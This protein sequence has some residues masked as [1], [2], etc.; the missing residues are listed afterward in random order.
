[1]KRLIAIAAALALLAMAAALLTGCAATDRAA[2]ARAE[3]EAEAEW[4][5]QERVQAENDRKRADAEAYATK[6]EA[7]VEA[8]KA[9]AAIL[10]AQRQGLAERVTALMPIIGVIGMVI[11]ALLI[12]ALMWRSWSTRPMYQPQYQPPQMPPP[13]RQLPRPEIHLHIEAPKGTSKADYWRAI[14]AGAE[15]AVAIVEQQQV[16]IYDQY[17]RRI[18]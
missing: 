10:E 17:G 14:S 7:Q 15:R 5:R 3:A 12:F 1:M 18:E 9:E 11:V 8:K 16:D 4:A 13:D 2:A 6:K